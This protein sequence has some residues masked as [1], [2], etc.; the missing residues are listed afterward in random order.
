MMIVGVDEAWREDN[1]HEA[2][3][4]QRRGAFNETRHRFGTCPRRYRGLAFGFWRRLSIA[5]SACLALP[6][7]QRRV[8]WIAQVAETIDNPFLAYIALSPDNCLLATGDLDGMV[9]IWSVATGQVIRSYDTNGVI[10]AIP[11]ASDGKSVLMGFENQNPNQWYFASDK[12]IW[13]HSR[14]ASARDVAAFSRDGKRILSNI[15]VGPLTIWNLDRNDV[16]KKLKSPS[17][18]IMK[19]S[20]S[21]DGRRVAAIVRLWNLVVWD[22]ATG[23]E[24]RRFTHKPLGMSGSFL[25][26]D[27]RKLALTGTGNYGWNPH[28]LSLS[29]VNDSEYS[30]GYL[31]SAE[32][33]RSFEKFE[34]IDTASTRR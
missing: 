29:D 9:A 23:R 14:S 16:R 1:K 6:G 7:S 3:G 12:T 22:A 2:G 4:E 34:V 19:A 13:G 31:W 33:A 32:P 10:S 21:A 11:F 17:G 27:D 18:A 15:G 20:F 25:L 8:S 28:T 26:S 5:Q 24:S 30:V